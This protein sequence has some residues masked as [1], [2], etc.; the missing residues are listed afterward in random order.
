MELWDLYDADERP[1]HRTHRRGEPMEKGT[2]HLGVDIWVL[3]GDGHVLLTLRSMEKDDCPGEWEN[4]CGSVLAGE[5]ALQGAVRE[6][7]EE[8]GIAASP[9]ELTL[10]DRR[11]RTD[12]ISYMY[13]LKRDVELSS[14]RMQPG[15]TSA[16]RL[17][18]PD[19]IDA[20]VRRPAGVRPVADRW[21]FVRDRIR[22]EIENR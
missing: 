8:T 6:L 4:T 16:A 22:A 1:L 11:V 5:T 2:Y 20:L 13:L 19:E 3:T 15:E 12:S 14:L 9:A 21:R 17:F 18:T 7:Y 10:I